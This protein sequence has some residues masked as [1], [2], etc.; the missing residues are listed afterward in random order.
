MNS[1]N[2]WMNDCSA[3]GIN[4]YVVMR[5][6]SVYDE[7]LSGTRLTLKEQQDII[8]GYREALDTS[9]EVVEADI[10]LLEIN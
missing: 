5:G 9:I 6:H 7:I 3:G 10:S 8:D 1:E 2:I 4:I